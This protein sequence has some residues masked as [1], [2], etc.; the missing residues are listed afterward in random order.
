MKRPKKPSISPRTNQ[1]DSIAVHYKIT[2]VPA[3][4]EARPFLSL[5]S[6]RGEMVETR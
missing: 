2:H 5:V 6:S 3:I 1:R 4:A